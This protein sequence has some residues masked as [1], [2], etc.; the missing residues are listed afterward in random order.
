MS[1]KAILIPEG[2]HKH[3][4][5]YW[6]IPKR[7]PRQTSRKFMFTPSCLYDL[8]DEDQHDVNKLFGMSFNF[9]P[10]CKTHVPHHINSAR[11]GWRAKLDRQVIEIVV[12]EYVSGVRRPTQVI[13]EVSVTEWY[14]Y[15]MYWING[16]MYYSIRSNNKSVATFSTDFP[17]RKDVVLGYELDVYFGGNETAPHNITIFEK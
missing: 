4:G 8:K 17:L 15:M 5:L 1:I 7:L 3:K 9:F 14:E 11:F 2:R 6:R 16:K 13:T 12:Y 10:T